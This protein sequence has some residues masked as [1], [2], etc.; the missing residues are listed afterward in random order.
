MFAE[1]RL[2]AGT[3]RGGG[4]HEDLGRRTGELRGRVSFAFYSP[5]QIGFCT[6]TGGLSTPRKAAAGAASAHISKFVI[7]KKLPPAWRYRLGVRTEDSQSS[8]PGSIPGS[9]TKPLLLSPDISY[10]CR[11]CS[12]RP[13]TRH[14]TW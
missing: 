10:A 12:K 9:A 7:I 3:K 11:Q 8:N 4:R 13:G 5:I 1:R 14:N 2:D 6:L